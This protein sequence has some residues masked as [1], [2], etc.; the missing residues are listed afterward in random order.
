MLNGAIKY[1][2]SPGER[3]GERD[4]NQHSVATRSATQIWGT[5]DHENDV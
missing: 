2:A 1:A 5:T 4:N 3:R